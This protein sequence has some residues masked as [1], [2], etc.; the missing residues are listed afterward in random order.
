MSEKQYDAIGASYVNWKETP[1][2]KYS[3]VP[4]VRRLLAGRIEGRDVL[5]LACGTGYYSRLFKRWGAA[6]VV[7]ADISRAMVAEARA[8]EAREPAGIEYVVED[9]ARLPVL[10]AFDVA[11]AMYLLHY[12]ETA[13]VMRAMCRSISANLK[14]G[15]HLLALLPEPDYVM[16]KGDTER[17]G[18]SYRLVASLGDWRLVHADVHTEPP[19]A[20]EY[21]HWSRRVLT[22]SLQQAGFTGIQWHPFDVSPEGMAKFGEP[23]WRDI[24]TNPV[25][26][27]LTAHLPALP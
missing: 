2:P 10:T 11:A 18:F 24:L 6:R 14:P 8:I 19:F 21:R 3:E 17:Y 4:T 1:I 23:Y 9:V 16:G 27:A 13:E 25:S 26:T 15:G 20:I 7:G 12:A 5:D 22:E